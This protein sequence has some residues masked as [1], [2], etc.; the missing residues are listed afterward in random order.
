VIKTDIPRFARNVA[1]ARK[2]GG[3]SQAQVSA[4]SGVH[5]TEVSRIE[6][7]LRDP[8]LSTLIRLA[9]ALEVEPGRLLERI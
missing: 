7:G 9:H 6:R 4:R 1:E 3:F 8:R 2:E 5:P